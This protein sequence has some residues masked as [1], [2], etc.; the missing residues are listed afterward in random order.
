MPQIDVTDPKVQ[1]A[2]AATLR[3]LQSADGAK[4]EQTI[5]TIKQAATG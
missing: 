2:C 1:E 5:R 4:S 3:A